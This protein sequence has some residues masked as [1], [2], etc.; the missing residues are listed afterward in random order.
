MKEWKLG[1]SISS[2]RN[3]PLNVGFSLLILLKSLRHHFKSEKWKRL[4]GITA[5]DLVHENL[6]RDDRKQV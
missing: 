2:F 1:T 5:E 4:S 3:F 6:P